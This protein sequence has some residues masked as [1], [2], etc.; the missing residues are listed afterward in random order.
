MEKESK[1]ERFKR[2][3]SN[4]VKRILH[5]LKLLGN[6]SNKGMYSWNDDHMRKI[7]SAIDQ[8]YKMCK[9]QFAKN[10]KPRNFEL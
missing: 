4:R 3:A 8:E 1:E 5:D 9:A 7:W 6:C 10:S 2:V